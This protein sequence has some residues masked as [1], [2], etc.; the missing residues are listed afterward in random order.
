M[1]FLLAAVNAK[2]IHTNPALY[3]LRAY[4]G[5]ELRPYIHLAEY[6]INNRMEEILGD[7]YMRHP[8][9]IGLSC[10][11]WNFDLIREL[12][13]EIPKVLPETD[14]WLGGPEV[15]FESENLLKQFPGV[16]GIMI[17]EGEETFRDLLT[18]YA[19]KE[20]PDIISKYRSFGEI[21]GLVLG[22]GP[23]PE[24]GLTDF[25]GLPFI[26][27]DL[28]E[29]QNK[30]IYYETSRGC[31]FRCSYCLSSIDKQVRLRSMD[32]VKSELQFFLDHKV[33]Q[34]K[35][36]DRTF[37][38]NKNHAMAIWNY[39]KENDNGV[40]NFH[41][42][43]EANIMEEDELQL[44]QTMR[45]GLVQLE[46]GVQTTN[47][48]TLREINRPADISKIGAVAEAILKGQNI[49][50]HLDLIAGLPLEDYESFQKSFCEVY[51]MKPHQL[52]L[53]FL[54]VLKGTVIW[55]K[56]D[57]YGIVYGDRP[58]YE[59]LYTKWLSYGEILK[60]KKIEEMVELYYNSG[61]FRHTLKALLKEFDTPF[62]MYEE[63]AE[64]YQRKGYFVNAPARSCRYHVLLEFAESKA[65]D[66]RELFKELLTFDFYLRENAKSRP[67]FAADLSCWR[68]EIW[69]FYQREEANPYLLP[70]Y[71]PY[72]ARQTMKMTHMEVFH[73][74]VWEETLWETC[75]EGGAAH[76]N[77]ERQEKPWFV[78]FDYKKK[79]VLT[80]D[81]AVRD[82]R[83]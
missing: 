27:E 6:T 56:A 42:E 3:S 51:A 48:D 50:I 80:G 44:L 45:P 26:Y 21:P 76:R 33:P 40:T 74:P 67:S 81:A 54:K 4:A 16:R 75:H 79:D 65:P 36:I 25:A 12:L 64:F 60:L 37:N 62:A 5:K 10:Y 29:V 47:R 19:A 83:L 52:Q 18:L 63:L 68:D 30:I 20:N 59:V 82:M 13:A 69:R 1:Q 38:C 31:P 43:I 58:P 23:T 28:D 77:P 32:K 24:R 71:A 9:V 72:H 11:I 57:L 53:G 66:R 55:E 34:V 78:L 8:D 61:Q 41:F 49:H 39:I 35:L 73:Y 15:S 70:D 2:Y 22:D 14:I 46:I 17:G 7:L